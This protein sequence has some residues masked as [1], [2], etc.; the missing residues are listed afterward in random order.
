M[1]LYLHKQLVMDWACGTEECHEAGL[2]TPSALLDADRCSFGH[3]H[4]LAEALIS[5]GEDRRAFIVSPC[6]I[7][8][9]PRVTL[10]VTLHN[11]RM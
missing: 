4:Y 1:Y 8:R 11:G 5:E 3:G 10:I 2:G 9:V 6:H 7:D